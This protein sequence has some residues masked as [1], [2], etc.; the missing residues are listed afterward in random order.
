M[1]LFHIFRKVKKIGVSIPENFRPIW[2][3]S[4]RAINC[5]SEF[6]K[7][8]FSSFLQVKHFIFELN[9]NIPHFRMQLIV[10]N[11]S[12]Q[13]GWKVFRIPTRVILSVFMNQKFIFYWQKQHSS[14]DENRYQELYL[15]IST[16][17]LNQYSL[18]WIVYGEL[19]KSN[20]LSSLLFKESF[21]YSFVSV[22]RDKMMIS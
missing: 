13:I 9:V 6:V 18:K 12:E 3:E 17:G 4:L 1:K 14:R 15:W 19:E 2:S 21:I 11:D 5:I 22:F 10:R 20:C 8:T 16:L 7:L